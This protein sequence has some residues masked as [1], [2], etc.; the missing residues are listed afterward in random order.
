MRAGHQH[1]LLGHLA[2]SPSDVTVEPYLVT[3]RDESDV[4]P[5]FQHEGKEF[6][7][8][9]E[10]EIVYR[11]V[12]SLYHITPGDSLFFDA[13]APHGPERLDCLPIKFLSIISYHQ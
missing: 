2:A 10:G 4:F 5:V 9:L 13:D 12:N 1:K 7:Y 8:M 6:L 11:H 3:L